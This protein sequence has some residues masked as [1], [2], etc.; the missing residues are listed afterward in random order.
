MHV[1]ILVAPTAALELPATHWV[2]SLN[3]VAPDLLD[4]LPGEQSLQSVATRAPEAGKNFPLAHLVQVGELPYHPAGH[5]SMQMHP[6][7]VVVDLEKGGH[8]SQVAMPPVA[9]K[10]LGGTLSGTLSDVHF[11]EHTGPTD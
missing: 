11:W 5:G 1:S 8:C 6:S 2:Q 10:Y 7:P 4:H 3:A 9:K